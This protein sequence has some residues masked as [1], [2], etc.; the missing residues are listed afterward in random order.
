MSFSP[1]WDT[2][3]ASGQPRRVPELGGI[4]TPQKRNDGAHSKE[5]KWTGRLSSTDVSA[6]LLEYAGSQRAASS[7]TRGSESGEKPGPQRTY[8]RRIRGGHC[9]QREEIAKSR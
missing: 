9:R 2:I 6:A 5:D 8:L 3:S 4:N 7:Q 1:P